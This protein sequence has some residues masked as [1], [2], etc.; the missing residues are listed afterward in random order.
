MKIAFLFLT[1]IEPYSANLWENYLNNNICT[2]YCHSKYPD[3]CKNQ[4]FINSQI[5]KHFNTSWG[6]ISLVRTTLALLKEA[7]ENNNNTHFILLSDSCIPLYPFNKLYNLVT[8]LTQSN[9]NITK[10]V[11]YKNLFIKKHSQWIILTRN[12]VEK[13]IDPVNDFTDFFTEVFPPPDELYFSYTLDKLKIPY[14]TNMTTYVLW[15]RNLSKSIFKK[16]VFTKNTFNTNLCKN[17]P[18]ENSW[19]HPVV[20]SHINKHIVDTCRDEKCL[21][22]RKINNKTIMTNEY[23]GEITISPLEELKIIIYEKE[24][25]FD[26]YIQMIKQRDKKHK[27]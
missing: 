9:I 26:E 13:I 8:D 3:K 17:R 23:Y 22:L 21:F 25:I 24:Q 14:T 18:K 6:N 11:K 5:Q 4:L 10:Q 2:T 7:V 19:S 12:D 1:Y 15:K 27:S 16:Y 20:F